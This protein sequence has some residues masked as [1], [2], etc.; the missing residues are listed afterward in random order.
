MSKKTAFI[1]G[2]TGQD[3]SYLAEL[4]LDKGYVV[5]G[6]VRSVCASSVCNLKGLHT[7]ITS[8][9]LVLHQG[10]LTNSALLCA[11]MSK[12]TPT[13]VY[14]LAAQSHVGSSFECPEY[15]A[16][17]VA[18]GTIRLI[19]AIKSAGLRHSCRVY[20]ASTSELYGRGGVGMHSETTTF[21]PSS[22]YGVAK[23]CA[24]WTIVNARDQGMHASNGILFSHESPRR[25]DA[26]VTR[27]ITKAV[28]RIAS[29]E[30]HVLKLGNLDSGRDWGHAKDYVEGM[31]LMLQQPEPGDY[32]LA[33]GKLH[34][35]R[36]FV[37][38][39]FARAGI[40]IVWSGSGVDEVGLSA[41]DGKQCVEI[42]PGFYR[43]VE[44]A[45]IAGDASK[46]LTTLGW[47]AK[48]TFEELVAQMVDADRFSSSTTL[49][50]SLM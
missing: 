48:T 27:K 23:L 22:P 43:P 41:S 42:D 46:A 29:G 37:E 2:I 45:A 13:E 26:F 31:W 38:L 39:A 16:D 20:Q 1:T 28:A 6:L 33:T 5:H 19:E 35:V 36:E 15:T 12:I 17:V 18:L 50:P 47:V 11:L 49:K 8:E 30:P 32:V 9:T 4:L 14:N 24:Y 25:A 44:A 34:T 40:P 21:R 3:G 10:D 7:A